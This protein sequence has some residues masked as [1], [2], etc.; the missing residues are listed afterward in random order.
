M[1][2]DF[3]RN[4][5]TLQDIL[6]A[7]ERIKSTCIETKLIYS[8]DLSKEY[9]NKVYLKPENLQITGAFKI[10]GALNKIMKLTD[11]E[12][13]KGLI[14]SSAGNHAQGVAYSGHSLGIDVTIVMPKTT[15]LIKV[16]ATK[17][18][19]AKVV[20][21][22]D[23]YDAAYEEARTLEKEE[24]YTFIHPFNDIDIMAGQGTIALE[25]LEE[26]PEADIILVPVGG[27]GLISGIAVAAKAI[28]PHIKII[29]V[30]STGA[31]AM[32]LS[33]DSGKLVHLPY[34]DTIAD[35]AAVKKPG[36]LA[37][38]IIK[39]Y[40]DEIITLDDHDLIEAIFLLV[41]KHKLVAEATGALSVAA[42]KKLDVRDKKV[43]SVI[44]GGNIDVLTMSSLLN[45]GLYSRGRLFCFSVKLKDTPGQLVKIAE[46]LAKLGANVVK[47]DHNQFKALDRL[48][49][50]AL[51]VTVE[52]NGHHHIKQVTKTLEDEGYILE[53]IY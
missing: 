23:V 21:A 13:S 26:L 40:V 44:S 19:G 8:Y 35:G 48:T 22:G 51:E 41:E 37:F 49:Y 3:H 17:G 4:S 53:I 52:T 31:Q 27:G 32:K 1:S 14:A 34:V 24:G 15:P 25:I 5:L 36:D 46:I 47:L 29:G 43:V 7:K 33:M 45:H 38:D 6:D 2:S 39:D 16:E 30:E 28:N 10:R 12:K 50:V 9:H 42:L 18:W 20:L 11:A